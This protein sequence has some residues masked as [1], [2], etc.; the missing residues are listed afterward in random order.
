MRAVAGIGL[1]A[2]AAYLGRRQQG[3]LGDH[4]D[5][6]QQTILSGADFA[7]SQFPVDDDLRF[8][9][10]AT[11]SPVNCKD[12]AGP[13]E[14]M[15]AAYR[16]AVQDSILDTVSDPQYAG[17]LLDRDPYPGLT[18]MVYQAASAVEQLGF[19]PNIKA[20]AS[21]SKGFVGSN[22]PRIVKGRARRP[23]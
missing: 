19:C 13:L 11:W 8:G 17:Q 2:L 7:R 21:L 4:A 6:V 22:P 15:S 3:W 20:I 10:E 14:E 23:G 16:G 18:A 1:I 5:M 9:E 12:V